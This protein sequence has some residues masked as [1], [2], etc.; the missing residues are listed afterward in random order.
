MFRLTL[1]LESMR[2]SAAQHLKEKLSCT[3]SRYQV[4]CYI[5]E[6]FLYY[7]TALSTNGGLREGGAIALNLVVSKFAAV[8]FP[9][10]K[11][12]SYL[13]D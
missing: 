13:T 8:S 6:E 10:K 3:N 7:Y 4:R 11:N 2:A 5:L 1:N 9:R 12:T